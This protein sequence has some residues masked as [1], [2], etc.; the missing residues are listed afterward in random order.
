MCD[1]R[2]FAAAAAHHAR[3]TRWFVPLSSVV[4]FVVMRHAPLWLQGPRFLPAFAAHICTDS[5]S[6]RV[7]GETQSRAWNPG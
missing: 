1:L 6:T 5:I 4:P 7:W 3:S 2:R